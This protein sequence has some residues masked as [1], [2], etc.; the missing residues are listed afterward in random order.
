MSL[1]CLN[2]EGQTPIGMKQTP[3]GRVSDLIL[4][5]ST[6]VY[7]SDQGLVIITGCSH[8]GICNIVSYAQQVCG[9]ERVADIIGGFHLLN[10]SASQM[11]G[12]L[13]YLRQITPLALHACHCTDLN[14]KVALAGVAPL[15]DTGVGLSLHFDPML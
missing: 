1:W 15:K 5:G 9:D 13:D 3:D 12:T 6:L 8:A 14:S 4:D 2:F 10:P 11:A 7:K